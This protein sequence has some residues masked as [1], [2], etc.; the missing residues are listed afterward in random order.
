MVSCS[1]D[2]TYPKVSGLHSGTLLR[3][4][5]KYHTFATENKQLSNIKIEQQ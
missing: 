4:F 2:I 5:G 3:G 1:Y